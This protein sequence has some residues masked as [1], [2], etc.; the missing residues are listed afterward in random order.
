MMVFHLMWLPL[1]LMLMVVV[2]GINLSSALSNGHCP[3]V[4]TN[5]EGVAPFE[6]KGFVTILKKRQKINLKGDGEG[7]REKY[8][9]KSD[10]KPLKWY[11]EAIKESGKSTPESEAG[12]F[13]VID[14]FGGNNIYLPI[15]KVHLTNAGLDTRDKKLK[16]DYQFKITYIEN[17]LYIVSDYD[18]YEEELKKQPTPPAEKEYKII[19]SKAPIN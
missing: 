10:T 16:C 2:L 13:K 17:P 4:N 12:F 19:L 5:K 7:E 9:I 8:T 1:K 11:V 18:E 14:S 15:I 6:T 3:V